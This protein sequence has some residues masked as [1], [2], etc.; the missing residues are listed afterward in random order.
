LYNIYS[1]SMPTMNSQLDY[2]KYLNFTLPLW[3]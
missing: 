1:P 2:H 3:L